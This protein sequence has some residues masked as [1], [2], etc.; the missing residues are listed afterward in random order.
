M[1]SDVLSSQVFEL[2]TMGTLAAFILCSAVAWII[3]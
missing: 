2:V 1:L 3:G